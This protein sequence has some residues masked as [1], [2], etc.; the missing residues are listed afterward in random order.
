MISRL[1]VL[2]VAAEVAV[3]VDRLDEAAL[4]VLAKVLA[5]VQV[6]ALDFLQTHDFCAPQVQPLVSVVELID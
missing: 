4:E 6:G 2:A 1:P 5:R 3:E